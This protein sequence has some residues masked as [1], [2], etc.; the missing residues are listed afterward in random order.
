MIDHTTLPVLPAGSDVTEGQRYT[1]RGENFDLWPSEIVMGF[2]IDTV[3]TAA[4]PSNQIMKLVERT[5]TSLVFEVTTTAH[6]NS[7][8]VWGVFAT[9]FDVPRAKLD[10]VGI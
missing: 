9:G 1:I 7:A 5:A 2:T 3:L 4:L 6:Y 10:F 8:H